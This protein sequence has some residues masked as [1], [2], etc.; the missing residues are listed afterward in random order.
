VR[1]IAC[2]TPSNASSCYWTRGRLGM[3]NGTPA[4]RLWKVGTKRLLGIYSGPSVDRYGL[5][6]ENPEFPA[7]V[8]RVFEPLK[9]RVFADF[10]ICPLEPERPGVMQSVCI[11]GAKNIAVEK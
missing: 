1:K 11:E 10:E 5:D 2:K 7:N 6:N 3:S 9:N 8:R 4:F